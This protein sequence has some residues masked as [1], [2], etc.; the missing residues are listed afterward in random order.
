MPD[1]EE[2]TTPEEETPE[3]PEQL[4]EWFDT[5]IAELENTEG[6][7]PQAIAQTYVDYKNRLAKYIKD[8]NISDED[9]AAMFDSLKN[10][11]KFR[12]LLNISRR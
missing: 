3:T 9:A 5:K 4:S 7:T 8:N 12:N 11:E 2:Q 10:N 1:T 6:L